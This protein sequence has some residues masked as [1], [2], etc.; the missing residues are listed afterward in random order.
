M[1]CTFEDELGHLEAG[2]GVVEIETYIAVLMDQRNFN[3]TEGGGAGE[4]NTGKAM[5]MTRS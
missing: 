4:W 1:L 2:L 3:C 5:L